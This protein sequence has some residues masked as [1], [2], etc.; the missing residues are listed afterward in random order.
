ML[1]DLAIFDTVH[2]QRVALNHFRLVPRIRNVLLE[3]PGDQV[4][5]SHDKR[6]SIARGRPDIVTRSPRADLAR[7]K[8][9]ELTASE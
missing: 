2:V 8:K 9:L 4:S 3:D 5:F 1:H 6:G 7:S